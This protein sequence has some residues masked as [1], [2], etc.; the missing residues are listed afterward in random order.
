MDWTVT[1]GPGVAKFIIVLAI[2]AVSALGI[3]VLKE[4][5]TEYF[6]RFN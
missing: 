1:L 4:K 3:M 5:I 6:D 2:L